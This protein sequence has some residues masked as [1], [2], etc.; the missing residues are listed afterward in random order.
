MRRSLIHYWRLNLAVLLGAAVTTAVL[1]GA[2]IVGDSVRGSLRGLT[3]ERL[4]KI[5]DAMI[6]E[7]FFRQELSNDIENSPAF[8]RNFS[9]AA[10]AIL[11][12]GTAIH[13]K[14]KTRATKI[15]INGVEQNFLPFFAADSA[16]L[17]P[18][19]FSKPSGQI[20][21]SVAINQA[22]QNE[23]QAKIGD[24][25]LLSFQKQSEVPRES[26]L[27]RKETDDLVQTLRLTLTAIIPDRGI[28]R[29]GLRPQ[30]ALSRNAFVALTTLQKTLGKT[31]RANALL[32]ARQ[33]NA[34]SDSAASILKNILRHAVTLDD[35]GLKLLQHEDYF[36]LESRELILKPVLFDTV[37][38]IAADLRAPLQPVL[39][40]LANTLTAN[41][42]TIP[43]ST[44]SALHLTHGRGFDFLKSTS[45][46]F[47]SKL[48]EHEI[49][50]NEWAAHD[51]AVAIG[52]T[53]DMSYFAVG[54]RGELIIK[55]SRFALQG[56]VAIKGLAADRNLTPDFPG[57]HDANDMHS[58]NPPFPVDLNLIRPKDEKYWDQFRATPKAFVALETG[59]RLWGSRFGNLTS[60]RIGAA[61]DRDLSSTKRIFQ[62][63]LLE[64][65]A[66]E[67]NGFVFQPIKAQGLRAATGA[68]D[69]SGLFI[70]F[71]LFLI[72]SAALLVGL[73][74]RLGVENRAREIGLLLSVGYPLQ[75]VRK[76]FLCEGSVV[77]SLGGLLGIGG[78]M[79][80]AALLMT[81]LRT[82]WR[83]AV[84]TTFL[85]LHI[86]SVSLISG[87][88]ISFGV[89]AF[90]IWQ[91][92]QQL[93]KI[94][95]PA[96][97]NGV[98]MM[99]TMKPPRLA[100]MV[101]YGATVLA[102][103][104]TL[105]AIITGAISATALFF[106]T[107][108]LLLVASL[109][110][111]ALWFRRQNLGRQPLHAA[112]TMQIAMR[113]ST[114][115]ASR[116]L[117]CVTLVACACFVI[118]AVGANRREFGAEQFRKNSGTGGFALLAD[119]DI[120]LHHDL[121]TAAGRFELGVAEA[122]SNLFANNRVI[123][124]RVLPGEDASCLNLYQP[125]K[126]RI[127]G[128]PHEFIQR[129]GFLFQASTA[130]SN[131]NPWQLL[132]QEIAPEI[133]PAIGDYNSVKW[134][135]HRGL[136]Q[137]LAMQDEFGRTIKLRLL[138]LL[139]S[140]IFQ[141][142]IIISEANFLKHF[143]SRS[144]YAFFLMEASRA[145]REKTAQVLENALSDY[146]FDA[147]S[148]AEKLANYQ[149]VEN[150]YLSVFQAVGGLGLLL[151]TLGLGIVLIRNVI[152]RRG[153]M[154]TLRAFGFRRSVLATMLVR[155]N[156]FL[157]ICGIVIGSGAALIAVAPHLLGGQAQVPWLSLTVTLALVLVVGWLASWT[158]VSVA[159]RIP[160][161]AA[162]KAET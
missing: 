114:R 38:E 1:T 52:D 5:D 128:A 82:W 95:T 106:S 2:L 69:F 144:G 14:S 24:Q 39:T 23:L 48:D 105:A 157:I 35:F 55:K 115:F 100:R 62:K 25:I 81:G 73:L 10:P 79:L 85:S 121:N 29:F 78:A 141:G 142:E 16:N 70:G 40:Y 50:L 160:L 126:P 154:A 57:I 150:T 123:S 18:S 156:V 8:Q 84:G 89:I 102:A 80:Y 15:N 71:S 28:G 76:K 67:Q 19:L 51:L 116:S 58:W 88:L 125:Q 75:T 56:I 36:S 152:E 119:S 4:G 132:E 27:G 127:L 140:S 158:A 3:L 97:L 53:I 143:P 17:A 94:P 122:D 99:N 6:A 26:L 59:R 120:A 137:D 135:L 32:V 44:V 93:K 146:G 13:A 64:R 136:G 65:V 151:G 124:F 74:F 138:G 63:K 20:F 107:G 49:L 31:R 45:G 131:E 130:A 139:Q 112:S 162:L 7:K 92:I 21:P 155:E 118:V 77:A 47:V 134:I 149:A 145:D 37:K 61:P 43:Y 83:D 9:A 111:L 96:L 129:G 133:I 117:L 12:S 60:I 108:A 66:P 68:T 148:T 46:A 22:L 87:Y 113:N 109:A 153:E 104:S 159:L 30:Q 161:L 91:T 90:A 86:N 41:G 103:L 42:K 34:W 11:L 72:I 33:A 110:F 147:T 54:G 98:I 101:A